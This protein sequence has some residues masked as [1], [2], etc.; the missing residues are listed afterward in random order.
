[1]KEQEA[2]LQRQNQEDQAVIE[3]EVAPSSEKEDARERVADRNE[4]L[5][6]L[7]TQIAERENELP[8]RERVK[9]IFTKYGFTVTAIALA[10]GVTIGAIVGAISNSLKA[11]GKG[12][13]NGLK[14]IGQQTAKLL[15]SLL[16]SVVSFLFKTAG[17]AIGF[18][19]EHSWLLVVAVVAFVM[20]RYIKKRG[21]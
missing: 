18:L 4:E 2:E 7:Q 12:L 16:R 9:A 13:G 19:A 5:A 17:Q 8:L 3:N 6:R 15:P 21:A 14:A 10:A 11:L 20:E 1:M